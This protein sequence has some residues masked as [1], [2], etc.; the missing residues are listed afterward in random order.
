M[1]LEQDPSLP[2]TAETVNT[3][4]QEPDEE[5]AQAQVEAPAVA[6][7]TPQAA[8]AAPAGDQ[9]PSVDYSKLDPEELFQARPELRPRSEEEFLESETFKRAVQSATDRGIAAE[10]R[11]IQAEATKRAQADAQRA[12]AEERRRIIE[13]DDADALLDLEKANLREADSILDAVQRVTA[14]VEQLAREDPDLKVLGEDKMNEIIES[15]QRRPNVTIYDIAKEL[16]RARA[17]MDVDQAISKTTQTIEERVAQEVEARLAAAGVE[18]RSQAGDIGASAAVS[19][20]AAPRPSQEEMTYE[21]ASTLFGE[22][23]MSWDEFKPFREAHEKA[24]KR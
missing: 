14:A 15:V 20:G 5:D 3:K 1:T 10:R 2:L 7:A 6:P 24:R 19:G 21:K 11:R 16:H 8:P 12:A 23:E 4:V 17:A 22:G 9:T 18:S 13:E